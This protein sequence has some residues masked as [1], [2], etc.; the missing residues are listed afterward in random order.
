MGGLKER[1][2]AFM[3]NRW[4]LLLRCGYNPV[5]ELTIFLGA[6]LRFCRCF[7]QSSWLWWDLVDCFWESSSFASVGYVRLI[8]CGSQCPDLLQHSCSCFLCAK[9]PQEQG[10]SGGNSKGIFCFEWCS[11]DSIYTAINFPD[12][13]SLILMLA[14]GPSM[15]VPPPLGCLL[16]GNH[17]SG[18]CWLTDSGK[19]E[20]DE[21]SSGWGGLYLDVGFDHSRILAYHAVSSIRFRIRHLELSRSDGGFVSEIIVRDH[22]Y[23]R[24]ADNAVVQLVMALLP[25][26]LFGLKKFGALYNFLNLANPA[27]TLIFSSLI[28]SSIYDREAEKQAHQYHMEPRIP[29]SIL[30]GMFG[31]DEPPKCEGSIC[32]FLSS[33]IMSGFC[34]IAAGLSVIIVYRT[35]TVFAHFYGKSHT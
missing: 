19:C 18:R 15:C 1:F 16:D 7:A 34:I 8:I 12:Q 3:N 2:Q 30:S 35:K 4:F 5:L 23:P 20:E 24:P 28:A 6:C 14:L 21:R 25:L 31:V 33:M 9:L 27:G 29:R 17:N 26:E 13:G 32:L 10:S 11:F 22:A